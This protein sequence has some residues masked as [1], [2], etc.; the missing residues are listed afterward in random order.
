MSEHQVTAEVKT[1]G[2][3]FKEG[4][5]K[6]P[7]YQRPY[8]W[9]T[10]HVH[11]L[12]QD[13]ERE[14]AEWDKKD[15]PDHYEYRLGS[16]IMHRNDDNNGIVDGQQRLVSLT[17]ALKVLRSTV[18]LPLLKAKFGSDISTQNIRANYEFIK[19]KWKDESQYEQYQNFILN[20]CTIVVITLYDLDEAFQLFDSQNARGKELEPHDL[21]KAYHLREMGNNISEDRKLSYVKQWEDSAAREEKN[22]GLVTL[23][24]LIG[25]YLYRIRRWSKGLK[26]GEFTKKDIDEFKGATIGKHDYRY[27]HLF[28]GLD[29]LRLS[30]KQHQVDEPIINGHWFFEYVFHYL[31]MVDQLFPEI[32]DEESID[33]DGTWMST[34]KKIHAYDGWGRTGDAYVRNLFKAALLHYYDKFGDDDFEQAV[35]PILHWAYGL[36][37]TQGSIHKATVENHALAN[38]D[39]IDSG[40][41]RLI[42][43]SAHPLGFIEELDKQTE[44]LKGE[45]RSGVKGVDEILELF[46]EEWKNDQK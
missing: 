20:H 45:N 5:L 15:K 3:L 42:S 37:I 38:G 22:T 26:A 28:Q 2:E 19:R 10:S 46:P 17:L 35:S 8:K 21:L 24:S 43:L 36:R 33:N 29:A 1:V 27:V 16:V 44:K 18:D 9:T 12:M 31:E 39:T 14:A 41:F 23:R 30:S 34:Y 7:D 11:Q 6:I 13:I 32:D 40:A 4:D 25:L